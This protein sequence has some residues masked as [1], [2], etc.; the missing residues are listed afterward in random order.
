MKIKDEV[1]EIEQKEEKVEVKSKKEN[2]NKKIT[3]KRLLDYFIVYSIVG[4]FIET[5][6]ALITKG[7][8][9]S[10]QSCLYGPF[11]CIYGLGA[12]VMIPCLNKLKKNNFTLF[13]GGFIIGSIVEYCISLFAELIFHIKWWDYSNMAFN[14]N[15][16]ICLSFSFFWGI[17]AIFLMTYFNPKVDRLLEKIPKK[18]GNILT[19]SFTIII[20]L[21]LL[22]TGF[23]LKVFFTRIVKTYD[24]KLKDVN[25][26]T[27][28]E[29]EIFESNEVKW[30]SE[31]LFTDKKVLRAFPNIKVI[32][33]NDEIIYIDSILK[34]I[35]PYYFKVFEPR[36]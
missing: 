20:V 1:K 35:Q 32:G 29:P 14:I 24:L 23:G 27:I 22:I 33:E 19:I 21:D 3:I 9:E 18:Y 5:I 12:M 36:H 2:I 8:I 25:A 34:D 15:G 17:L 7:V 28:S 11:C 13:I 10:R 16:R 6:F 26:Y 30:L 31:N 4:F